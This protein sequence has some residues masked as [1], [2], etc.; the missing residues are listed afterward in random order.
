MELPHKGISVQHLAGIVPIASP[1][2]EFKMPWP[3]SMIP[4]APQV[5]A[6]ERAI[7]ECAMAGCETIWV[8]GHM[9]LEPIIKKKIG[10]FIIDPVSIDKY[11]KSLIKHIPIYFVPIHPRDKN[12][13]DCLSWSA[14][15]GA[16]ISYFISRKLSTWILPEKFYCAFPY[17]VTDTDFLRQN[18]YTIASTVK[19]SFVYN[20]LNVKDNLHI[21]FTFDEK[22]YF[23][24]SDTL[25]QKHLDEWQRNPRDSKNYDLK[26]ALFTLDLTSANL[27]HLPWFYDIS[28]WDG[29]R[30][31]IGSSYSKN[32]SINKEIFLNVKKFKY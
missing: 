18:R 29:Y 9:K 24:C 28:T 10:N 27:L 13:R 3:D 11:T 17:G 30:E 7:Y 25:K 1:P 16:R 19:T 22:D 15:Y 23:S 2:L 5:T 4:V 8:V 14:M 26:T 12:K 21:S 32:L 20:N 31:F 6:V